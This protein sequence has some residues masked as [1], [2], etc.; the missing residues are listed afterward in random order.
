MA[1]KFCRPTAT[2]SNNGTTWEN[3]YTSLQAA[4][5][6]C[7]AGDDVWMT[8]GVYSHT[9]T[10]DFDNTNNPD[11]IGGFSAALSGTDG[12]KEGR[13]VGARTTLNGAGNYQGI[14]ISGWAGDIDGIKF[15]NMH[16]DGPGP[17]IDAVDNAGE[18][19]I[20]NCEFNGCW[21]HGS[22]GAIQLVRCGTFRVYNT[23][24]K[25]NWCNYVGGAV[26]L[27]DTTYQT[28]RSTYDGNHAG[29]TG[30]NDGGA[31]SVNLK[32]SVAL[33]CLFINNYARY[34]GAVCVENSS[35][36][37]S[38]FCTYEGNSVSV[39]GGGGAVYD[40]YSH[41]AVN[42]IF[43]GNTANGATN[44]IGH[45]GGGT[46]SVTY[47]VVE[48]GHAGT[49]NKTGNPMFVG[50]G[51]H[52][53]ELT[54]PTSSAIDA[55]NSSA[56]FYTSSDILER[57]RVD[58]PD[59]TNTGV[60]TIAYAD[61][62]AY[63]WQPPPE[64][65][66]IP[67]TK[68]F[69]YAGPGG[70][71]REQDP[72]DDIELGGL[73]MSGGIDMNTNKIT[74]LAAAT[75]SGDMLSYGQSGAS[76]SGLS[77]TDSALNMFGQ[78]ITNVADATEAH[79]AINRAQL[80]QAIIS[81]GTFKELLVHESQLDST[82]GVLAASSLT[83]ASQPASGDTITITDGTTTR[84]YGAASGGDVQY[85]IGATV[86]DTM[87]NLA[88][89]IDGDGSSA[90]TSEFSTDLG[91]IDADG[92]VIV[93]EKDNDGTAS[94][95]Y[96][97]WTTPAN[98][99]VV[100]Y[101]GEAEYTKKTTSNLPASSPASSNFGIRRTQ[102]NLTPGEMHYAENSD[103]IYGWD[104][105]ANQWNTFSGSASLADATAAS[106]GGVKG[107]ITVDS[108][109]GLSVTTGTLSIDLASNRGLGFSSGELEI[110]ENTSAG[111]EVTASGIGIDLAASNP[112]LGFD[113]SGDLEALADT[114][115]G[116]EK[117][118]SGLAVDLA[119]TTPGLGFDGS[120]D[121]QAI[122]VATGGIEKAAGGLQVKID[123]T[124][125]TLDVDADGLKVVGLPSLF[126]IDG[127]AVSANVTG[128]NLDELTG[129]G[130]T[131]LHSHA[132][133]GEATRVE[134]SFTTGEDMGLGDPVYFDTTN[135]QVLKADAG[136]DTKYESIGVAKAIATSGNPVEVVTLGPA[137]VLS[138][139]T[140]GTRYYLD[141]TGGLTTSIPAGQVWVCV[142]GFAVDAD[143]LFVM[144]KVLHKQY[145]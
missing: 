86:A 6:A 21:N 30:G 33:G 93:V 65:L 23:L 142:V 127:T 74:E 118:A 141:N 116:I 99:Q 20:R 101:T 110:A 58:D 47:C 71:L 128:A 77:I 56:S 54:S 26:R 143:T 95:I 66:A 2:G 136:S 22:G 45:T 69:L 11:F 134:N 32:T 124:P 103:S 49:G 59:V 68:T 129:G 121:L 90:W 79:H 35:G 28:F 9:T 76:L 52:P 61:I 96:G 112:A 123:D 109:Y 36:W 137:D 132:G 19:Y 111:L 64:P 98:I 8:E 130:A 94:K 43:W 115:A 70:Y 131:T 80:D 25:D 88:A 120:G 108:D 84:T 1:I 78:Q 27:F 18:V 125:D 60:G 107:K 12:T 31:I 119:T 38:S 3:A 140:A 4:H 44:S 17:A 24:F 50:T 55:A 48:G 81:G 100:D 62:G 91:A 117:T 75:A 10:L 67:G 42:S 135:N 15:L 87:A 114:T 13:T 41:T 29:S 57:G 39:A 144:P 7:G 105:D 145:A 5:D 104:D 89:A 139:A 83:M 106:G 73:E 122:V 92:V 113:G 46:L 97:V 102:A 133:A 14:S 37:V 53:Y 34:G 51:D 63:E 82:E 85:A 126:K 72:T 138:G 16:A 40:K